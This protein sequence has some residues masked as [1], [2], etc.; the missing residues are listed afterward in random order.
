MDPVLLTVVPNVLTPPVTDPTDLVADV[1]ELDT[2]F[3]DCDKF[4]RVSL[5]TV[6]F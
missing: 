2:V 5:S 3:N 1:L 6:K 4:L